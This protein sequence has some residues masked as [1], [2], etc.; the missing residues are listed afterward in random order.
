MR[1]GNMVSALLP[2]I[3]AKAGIH[4]WGDVAP[5]SPTPDTMDSGLR[6]NDE[7]GGTRL[8][9]FG[10]SS[11]ELVEK[12]PSRTSPYR[13]RQRGPTVTSSNKRRPNITRAAPQLVAT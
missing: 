4:G 5:L 3:P 10:S 9:P 13:R 7:G 12:R 6:R 2:V 8:T 1:M 11:F